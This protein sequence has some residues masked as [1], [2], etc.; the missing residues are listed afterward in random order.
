MIARLVELFEA[1][2]S[3]LRNPMHRSRV[4]FGVAGAVSQPTCCKSD[5]QAYINDPGAFT[6]LTDSAHGS[7]A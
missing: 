3:D 7:V 5:T 4:G 6:T 1:T 2:L